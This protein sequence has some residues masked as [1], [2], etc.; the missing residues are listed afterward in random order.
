ML[1]MKPIAAAAAQPE[2]TAV[3]AHGTAAV[4][5]ARQGQ[6]LTI[7]DVA[8]GRSAQLFGFTRA[9]RREFLSVHHTRVFSNSYVLGL[10]MRLVTNR[11]RPL[12]V[13]GRDSVRAHDLLTPASTTAGLAAAGRSGETGCEE[14]VAAALAAAGVV[15]PKRPDPI[16]LFLPVAIAGDGSLSLGS[17]GRVAGGFVTFR[18]LIDTDFVV[19]ATASDFDIDE[20]TGPIEVRVH[21]TP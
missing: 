15:A 6:L 14:A 2:T 10:G 8:G 20:G 5:T 13:L 19:A 21:E 16:N 12:M 9:D 4:V 11:R 18:V 1:L 3:V 7:T 17:P